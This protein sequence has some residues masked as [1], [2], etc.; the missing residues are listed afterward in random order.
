[1]KN[2]SST[3]CQTFVVGVFSKETI[4]V[5]TKSKTTGWNKVKPGSII[6]L[7]CNIF[8]V[9]LRVCITIVHDGACLHS[10]MLGQVPTFVLE[11]RYFSGKHVNSH[12]SLT[13]SNALFIIRTNIRL[14]LTMLINFLI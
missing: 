2:M 3:Y 8:H 13:G 4:Q 7:N 10:L 14:L 12:R 9:A 11:V 6:K 1:M 5:G